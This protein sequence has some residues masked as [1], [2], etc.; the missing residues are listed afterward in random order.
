MII[1]I[2]LTAQHLSSTH[3]KRGVHGDVYSNGCPQQGTVSK[4]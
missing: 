3:S 2:T 4:D 1:N